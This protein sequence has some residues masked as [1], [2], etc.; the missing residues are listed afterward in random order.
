M[1]RIHIADIRIDRVG[2]LLRAGSVTIHGPAVFLRR[3]GEFV[4]I[5]QLLL[6][7]ALPSMPIPE[8]RGML[9]MRRFNISSP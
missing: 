2:A 9:Y 8:A 4:M 1:H 3:R 6:I 7:L 5:V